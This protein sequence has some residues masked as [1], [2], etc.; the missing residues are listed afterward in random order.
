MSLQLIIF[1]SVAFLIPLSTIIVAFASTIATTIL[2]S[3][4]SLRYRCVYVGVHSYNSL[5]LSFN[6]C[7]LFNWRL[8]YAWYRSRRSL[9]DPSTLCLF[10]LISHSLSLTSNASP[11]LTPL[12]VW[13]TIFVWFVDT[14]WDRVVSS[15]YI[16]PSSATFCTLVRH[17]LAALPGEWG[18]LARS[19]T[20]S[21]MA[22][23]RL[24]KPLRC[25]VMMGVCVVGVVICIVVD[26]SWMRADIKHAYSMCP[27]LLRFV[28]F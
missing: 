5:C 16:A 7:H 13:S 12:Q 19:S 6:N 26:I 20:L 9:S 10:A 23:L 4:L 27:T 15:F 11:H 14:E 21:S 28:C 17:Q 8:L 18:T 1:I 2:S 25:L 24:N 22:C 3:S